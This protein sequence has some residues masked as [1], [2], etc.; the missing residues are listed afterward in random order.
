MWE[1]FE[2]I[3]QDQGITV[4]DVSRATGISQSTLSNWKARRNFISAKNGKI[5]AEYLG[6]SYDY[7]M[8]GTPK[9]S[10]TGR[11]YRFSDRAAQ[12]AEKLTLRPDLMDLLSAAEKLAP[13]AVRAFTATFEALAPKAEA[14]IG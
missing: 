3:L 14:K 2:E 6:V 8:G 9:E 7:L 11:T 10:T 13:E 1:V 12:M 5:I 4:A